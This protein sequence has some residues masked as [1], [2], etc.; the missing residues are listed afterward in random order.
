MKRRRETPLKRTNP[1]GKDVWVARYT[2]PD[3]K[4][5]SAGTYC[6]KRGPRRDR[7]RARFRYENGALKR[8]VHT[9]QPGPTAIQGRRGPTGRTLVACARC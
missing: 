3:G 9:P 7:R 4:R 8:L 5:R 6:R 1:S 2:G